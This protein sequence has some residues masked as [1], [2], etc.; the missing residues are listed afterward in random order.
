MKLVNTRLVTNRVTGLAEFYSQLLGVSPLG[1]DDYVELRLEQGSAIAISSKESIDLFGGGAAE[2]GSNRSV[3][4]DFEVDDVDQQRRRLAP[5]VSSFVV[6]P[7]DQP[8]GSRAMLFRD[9]DGTL[10]NFFAAKV[11]SSN[12]RRD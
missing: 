7:T 6:E 10:I 8:W 5:L 11:R 2:P 9:P 1:S 3:I 12:I 4:L